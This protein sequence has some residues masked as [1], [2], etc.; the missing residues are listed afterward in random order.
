MK[1]TILLCLVLCSCGVDVA[2][3]SSSSSEDSSIDIDNSRNGIYSCSYECGIE[4]EDD[5]FSET[6]TYEGG[7]GDCATLVADVGENC[8]V[9][10]DIE[11][12]VVGEIVVLEEDD[13]TTPGFQF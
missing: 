9:I 10:E 6:F 7:P 1:I 11:E 8:V 12:P 3:D 4:G 2:N 5:N 13:E